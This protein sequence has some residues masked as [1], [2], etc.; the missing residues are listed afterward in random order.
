MAGTVL[1]ESF[2]ILKIGSSTG[3]ASISWEVFALLNG[4]L[5][6]PGQPGRLGELRSGRGASEGG[7]FI[8]NLAHDSW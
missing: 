2:T 3:S 6:D 7:Q 1:N 8:R 4:T 5:G